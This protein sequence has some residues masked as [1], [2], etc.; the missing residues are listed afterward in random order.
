MRMIAGVMIIGLV[1]VT[2]SLFAQ[3]SQ[4]EPTYHVRSVNIVTIHSHPLGYRVDYRKSD[5]ALASFYLPSSWFV[6]STKK[7][8]IIFGTAREYPYFSVFW[9]NREF[10]I[11]RLYVRKNVSDIS[12]RRLAESENLAELFNVD[13]K[14]FV[15][16]I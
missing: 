3:D 4:D 11:I 9:V 8:Q 6:G 1:L 5:G 14:E 2:G 13:P 10:H 15:L 12:W 7:A 16:E